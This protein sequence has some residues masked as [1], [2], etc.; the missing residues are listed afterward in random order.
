MKKLFTMITITMSLSTFAGDMD[1]ETRN[2]LRI[3]KET[4]AISQYQHDEAI[5][6]IKEKRKLGLCERKKPCYSNQLITDLI[7]GNTTFHEKN[8]IDDFFDGFFE[9]EKD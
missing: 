9:E 8:L 5:M 2:L 7:L 3:A 4:H 6:V 1:S